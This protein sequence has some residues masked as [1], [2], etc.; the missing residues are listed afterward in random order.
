VD[1]YYRRFRNVNPPPIAKDP[2]EYVRNQVFSCFFNDSVC[3]RNSSS[4]GA[5][6][7]SCGRT[8]FPHPNSTWPNSIKVIRR[9]LGHLPLATQTKVLAAN[10]SRLYGLDMAALPAEFQ[11]GASSASGGLIARLIS[12]FLLAAAA[13]LASA[14]SFADLASDGG[15]SR[16]QR[17]VQ[18]ARIEG[19][20]TVYT[21]NAR[22]RSRY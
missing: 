17:L 8:I 6:T 2:S 9:D 10:V 13:P 19:S 11:G 16:H 3:G 1:Y 5:R 7:T 18:A 20:L 22:I 4:G 12:A 15:P 21:S 14:Q